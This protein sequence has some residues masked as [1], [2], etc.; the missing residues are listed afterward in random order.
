VNIGTGQG[1]SLLDLVR[2]VFEVA[3]ADP[4]LIRAGA[5]AYR[6]SEVHRLVMD[7][8]RT[9]AVLRGFRPV[10]PLARGLDALVR[11]ERSGASRPEPVAGRTDE[12]GGAGA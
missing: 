6:A 4:G 10:T 5:R 7:G 1:I 8:S 11:R 9:R 12:D 2:L 3:G